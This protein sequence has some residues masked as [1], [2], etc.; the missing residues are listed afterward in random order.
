M[1]NK[2]NADKWLPAD[3]LRIKAFARSLAPDVS[4]AYLGQECKTSDIQQALS[5]LDNL[6]CPIEISDSTI[7]SWLAGKKRPC[8]AT[9]NWIKQGLPQCADWLQPEI[10]SSPILRFICALDIWGS[11]IDS[12]VR[13]L[14]TTLPYI[15]VGKGLAIL[16]KR[17]AS[18][19]IS[20][21]EDIFCGFAIPRLKCRVPRQI[22]S[23]VYQSSNLLTLMD[24]MFRCGSCLELSEEEFTEWAIDLAALTLMI[25]A[26]LEGASHAER[27]QSGT[28]GDYNWLAYRIF[29]RA[30][31][32]WPNLES[33]RVA[34][35]DFSEFD[36]SVIDYPQRLMLAREVL[37]KK[38]LSIGSDLS[39]VEVLFGS[40][41]D[42]NMMW[43]EPLGAHGDT[44]AQ[45]GLL[46]V[47]R[48]IL[49]VAPGRYRYELRNLT[50][51][52]RAVL[53]HNLENGTHVLVRV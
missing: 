30:H 17:W 18:V 37:R 48:N 11:S 9:V 2:K 43:Q 1:G 42:R 39:I 49:P 47:K 52:K 51:G 45:S 34:L 21:G 7:R 6:F 40:I 36:D 35:Q 28:T 31:G 13:K 44:I 46:R 19:P 38:L 27:S 53:C 8:Q 32:N 23:A 29:F 3:H 41:K 33:V 10:D 4:E 26:F 20:E 16:A 12:P 22:P 15:T 5:T 25:G 24:F 14:D 50:K